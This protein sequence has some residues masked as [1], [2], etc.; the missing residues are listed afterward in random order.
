MRTNAVTGRRLRAEQLFLLL[1]AEVVVVVGGLI[2]VIVVLVEVSLG[3][4][5]D[6]AGEDCNGQVTEIVQ[7]GHGGWG[8]AAGPLAARFTSVGGCVV[9]GCAGGWGAPCPTRGRCWRDS[10]AGARNVYLAEYTELPCG[11]GVRDLIFICPGMV[12]VDCSQPI[13]ASQPGAG[14]R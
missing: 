1:G 14:P 12:F 2:V 3:A 9:Q 4:V 13:L 5:G 7:C 8:A 11:R 10:L 6:E